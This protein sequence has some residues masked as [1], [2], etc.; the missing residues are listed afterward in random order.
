MLQ[1]PAHVYVLAML[2]LVAAT[3]CARAARAAEHAAARPALPPRPLVFVTINLLHGG[4]LSGLFGDEADVDERL[5]LIAAE[6]ERTGADVVGVQEASTGRARGNTARR[7][8]ERLGFDYVYAPALFRFTG[9]WPIDDLIAAVMNF[10]EGPA[11]LSRFPIVGSEVRRLPRCSGVLDVRVA[12]RADVAT[13]W[14][15]MPVYSTHLSWG[16]CESGELARFVAAKRNA[17]PAVVMGDFNATADMPQMARLVLEARLED[18]FHAAN[19]TERGATV[20]QNPAAERRTVSRRV[21]FVL[22]GAGT[23]RPG[24][25]LESRVILDEPHRTRDGRV[26]WPSDH[27]GVLATIDVAAPF[28]SRA[29][30]RQAGSA[31]P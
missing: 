5:D 21:D 4:V 14:G 8:A 19:P 17:L 30:A 10:T 22:V 2:V 16:A 11:V 3:T 7:L 24:R 23:E 15:E 29:T 28:D 1:R 26:V 12:V 27:Y 9:W 13:P 31:L 20:W 25:V 18:A 6:L